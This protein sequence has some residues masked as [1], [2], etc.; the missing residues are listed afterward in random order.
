[1]D[2]APVAVRDPAGI[3]QGPRRVIAEDGRFVVLD[4]HSEVLLDL[5]GTVV[6]ESSTQAWIDTAEG[7][8]HIRTLCAC[9]STFRAWR[10]EWREA[11][12]A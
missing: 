4:V 1:M 3:Q 2:R 8:W 5:E 9:N 10:R 12:P 6:Q 11:A 7:R